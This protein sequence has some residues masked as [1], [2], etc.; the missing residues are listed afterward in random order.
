MIESGFRAPYYATTLTYA[1]IYHISREEFQSVLS[2][3]PKTAESLTAYAKRQGYGE[4]AVQ[5]SAMSSA[6]ADALTPP[7]GHFKEAMSPAEMELR[8]LKSELAAI[9]SDIKSKDEALKIV[10]SGKKR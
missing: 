6:P 2:I 9:V 10:T 1:N 3:F 8:D 7:A 4:Y 5:R